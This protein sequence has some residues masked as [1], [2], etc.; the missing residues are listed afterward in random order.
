[1]RTVRIMAPPTTEFSPP[2]DALLDAEYSATTAPSNCASTTSTIGSNA[3]NTV[4]EDDSG[5]GW[6]GKVLMQMKTPNIP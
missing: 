6:A 1:V 5:G 3:I 2:P 4:V